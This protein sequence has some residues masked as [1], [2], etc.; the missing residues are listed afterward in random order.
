MRSAIANQIDWQEIDDLIK[1]ATE[2]GDPVASRIK[3]LKLDI[4]H[5]SMLL[6]DPFSHLDDFDMDEDSEE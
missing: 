4:N 6:T 1:E 3:K 5:F 2:A